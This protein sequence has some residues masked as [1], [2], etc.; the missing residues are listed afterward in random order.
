[1][2]KQPIDVWVIDP[3]KHFMSNSTTSGIVLFSSALLALILTNSPWANAFHHFWENTFSIGFGKYMVSKS[4]HHWINDGLMAVFFFVV[5]LELKREIIAGELSNPKNAIL[6]L[7]AALGGMVFP[8][9][10]YLFFN[11]EGQASNGWGIAMATDIAF[12]LGVLYLLGSKV[13]T[14]LKIFLTAL[15]IADDIGAVLVIAFFYTSDINLMSLGVGALFFAI[16]ITAN[17]IGVRSTLFY[18]IVGI[19][20]LWLAFLMSGVHA[21]I[22]AVIAAF[23]IPANVK[24]SNTYFSEK[25]QLLLDQFKKTAP[26]D[27]STVTQDQ[28]HILQDIRTYSKKALTPLQR[29]EHGLHPVVAFIIMPIFALS[30]AGVAITSDFLNQLNS[31]VTYG[32]IA[33]LILGKVLGVTGFVFL[34]LKLKWA[35]LP[36]GMNKLHVF[37]VA[38]LAAIGFTMSLFISEL[39][40]DDKEL[41]AQAKIGI[42]IAS[43]T[44]SFIGFYLIK[45]AGKQKTQTRT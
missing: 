29:L 2:K 42:L 37:G 27:N 32:I 4:L 34:M 9:L 12:A 43:L 13:P 6:P 31:P 7:V 21:T 39:A 30:N 18:G 26:N 16:L 45:L 14:S 24:V 8:A 20:G 28:M 38:F 3:M 5:G 1:M 36:E 40:F 19:G 44:A 17:F 33:G 25:A 15:A 11:P 35:T 22:A 41:V 10:L 23:T